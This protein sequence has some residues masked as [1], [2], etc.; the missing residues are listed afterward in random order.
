MNSIE[1]LEVLEHVEREQ[2]VGG[3]PFDVLLQSLLK[4]TESK[5]G[6]IAS[7]KQ[8]T[9]ET[10]KENPK[11]KYLNCISLIPNT[12]QTEEICIMFKNQDSI[13]NS[14]YK[15]Y[16]KGILLNTSDFGK[17]V[18]E[19]HGHEI[20]WPNNHSPI[21]SC[22]MVPLMQGD[23]LLGQIGLANKPNGYPSNISEVIEPFILRATSLL[24]NYML[25]ENFDYMIKEQSIHQ[26]KNVVLAN[27]SH[28]VRTP[29]NTILGMNALLL[30]TELD[31]NQYECLLVQRKSCYH[32]LGLITDILDINKLE[33]G[34]MIFKHSAIN[35][36]EL[37]ETSYDLIGFDAKRRGLTID[38]MIDPE[39]PE[40][41]IG[42]KQRLKQML[43]NLLSNAVK[44][45]DKGQIKTKV[46]LV[47]Q[48]EVKKLDLKTPVSNYLQ[49][50]ILYDEK[51]TGD[52]YYVKFSVKDTGIGIHKND[53]DRL[54]KSYE[55]LDNSNTKR[56]KGTGLG[57]A[58]TSEL[59]N[60]MNGKIYVNSIF[61]K[62]STFT[63]IVPLQSYDDPKK[64][65]DMSILQ[66]KK[67]LVVDDNE[68]NLAILTN[69]L[70]NWGI[71]YVECIS[72]SRALAW[73]NKPNQSFDLGLLDIIMP[74]MDG[75][76]LAERI[77]RSDRPFPLIALSSDDGEHSASNFF[78]YQLTKPYENNHLLEAIIH[79]LKITEL[80]KQKTAKKDRNN[81]S[82]SLSE[83]RYKRGINVSSDSDSDGK[84]ELDEE[85][86]MN[87]SIH[88][89]FNRKLSIGDMLVSEHQAELQ[90]P[91]H[92]DSLIGK[93]VPPKMAIQ[94][95]QTQ[96][97]KNIQTQSMKSNQTQSI[98]NNQTQSMKNIQTQSMKNNQSVK[99][100]IQTDNYY[101]KAVNK[102]INI[103]VVEDQ[104]FNSIMLIKMLKNI[105]YHNIDLAV[106]GP[107]AVAMVKKNKGVPLIKGVK[108]QYDLI[109]MDIIMPG[110][111][112]GVAASK[113]I[114]QL[115]RSLDER[116]KI[117]AVTASIF[118][119]VVE[120]YMTDGQMDGF[121]TKPIDKID[122]ITKVL[123][124]IG[125]L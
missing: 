82:E 125:F 10:N 64:E 42:D 104:E 101:E 69:L 19:K 124:N 56:G 112:D 84:N 46:E 8:S 86:Y 52:W 103:L 117:V 55:Q 21:K 87:K 71:E 43:S 29:L 33:A 58:I 89:P 62:G 79:V 73:V 14:I 53:M 109:L 65:L 39:V 40:F 47:S 38:F 3:K 72:S 28:E 59:C 108:S 30:E 107:D 90:K 16:T 110:K 70:D 68:K 49:P 94:S 92:G 98:K 51:Y 15:N 74:N 97:A 25:R 115:F 7:V 2:I 80:N 118:D 11:G 78:S 9:S 34:K 66:G 57:L 61:G 54:F 96:S 111:Y 31:D 18:K 83:E 122:C 91:M 121:I 119:G 24:M 35:V 116:P 114:T 5:I 123:R 22:I 37:I 50:T 88:S 17:W 75:N 76:T 100:R 63:F 26:T 105:G 41:L 102:N 45:T 67:L 6:Y 44:F 48:N 93:K 106:S 60:L 113:K 32:L 77:S 36:K 23:I 1:I 27:I 99:K 81:S 13:F 4:I 95:N 120:Q 12:S 20:N 85:I